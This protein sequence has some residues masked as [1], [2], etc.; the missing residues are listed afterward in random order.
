MICLEGR[1]TGEDTQVFLY[2]A[3]NLHVGFTSSVPSSETFHFVKYMDLYDKALIQTTHK[4][5][6][7]PERQ[8]PDSSRIAMSSVTDLTT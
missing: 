2:A 7:K 6:Y 5:S 8:R 4:L 1:W 3:K